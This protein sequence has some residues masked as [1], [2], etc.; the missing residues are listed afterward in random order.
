MPVISGDTVQRT[1]DDT[2]DG[3]THKRSPVGINSGGQGTINSAAQALTASQANRISGTS[4]P[5]PTEVLKVGSRFKF[6]VGTDKTAAGA[7][8]WSVAVKFGTADTTADAAIATWT[9]G[10]NTAAADQ[11]RLTFEVEILTLGAAATAK[12]ICISNNTLTNVTGLGKIGFIPG[13]TATFNSNA[14]LPFL[15][16]DITPG[17][18]AVMTAVGAA[19]IL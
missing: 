9:S 15:H 17:A 7:A 1:Q 4:I 18:S 13:S 14:V 11:S 5:L 16:L 8:P 10:T 6:E 19:Q 3:V 2:P 12:C